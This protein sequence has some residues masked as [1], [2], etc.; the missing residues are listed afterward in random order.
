M[1]VWPRWEALS[2]SLGGRRGA[3]PDVTPPR[4]AGRVTPRRLFAIAAVAMVLLGVHALLAGREASLRVVNE[5]PS[6]KVLVEVDDAW[7]QVPAGDATMAY[8]SGLLAHHVTVFDGGCGAPVTF[9][10]WAG[11]SLA[12]TVAADGSV[13]VGRG[14]F[15]EAVGARS[16]AI[17]RPWY[18][19]AAG[20]SLEPLLR[21]ALLRVARASAALGIGL[22]VGRRFGGR[23]TMEI[24]A[25][26][27]A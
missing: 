24:G 1:A 27:D 23:R 17:T 2:G 11:D 9:D 21:D 26:A 20:V 22:V 18:C 3:K 25:S 19:P 12:M 7:Y 16:Q 10:D 6:G 15:L 8:A 4:P 14:G 13:T 5:M